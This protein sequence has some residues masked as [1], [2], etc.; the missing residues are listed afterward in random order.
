MT[1]T[2]QEFQQRMRHD[3]AFRQRILAARKAGTLDMILTQ[4]CYDFDLS[5]LVADLPQV[6]TGISAGV[7]IR[8]A[9]ECYCLI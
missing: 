5:L 6:R 3:R 4:E 1:Q 2:V 9:S 7:G 8:T